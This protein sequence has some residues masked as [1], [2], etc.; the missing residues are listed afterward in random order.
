MN[1]IPLKLCR[2]GFL[3]WVRARNISIGIFDDSING[4][5]GRREKFGAVYVDVEYHHDLQNHIASAVPV[6]ELEEA[7]IGILKRPEEEIL[8]YL[9]AAS[10]RFDV[11]RMFIEMRIA[12][13]ESVWLPDLD[14]Y[15]DLKERYL[16]EVDPRTRDEIEADGR[17]DEA[18]IAAEMQKAYPGRRK[19][20]MESDFPNDPE[21]FKAWR[22]V[23]RRVVH[24]VNAKRKASIRQRLN[25]LSGK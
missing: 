20:L 13:G 22:E 11:Q 2:P 17:A 3:Y 12:Q 14:S 21:G 19:Y 5:H 18:A 1:C 9:E 4:F 15:P 24:E 8:S 7:P 25:T 16:R 23:F 10:R 6:R